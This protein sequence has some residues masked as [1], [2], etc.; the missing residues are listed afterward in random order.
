[1]SP[2]PLQNFEVIVV[3]GGHA[4]TE[5]A[6]AAAR[7][8]ARTL[9][10]THNIET[11]GQMSC[12]PAIG[13]IGKGH[14]VR[15][16]DALGGAM[17]HAADRAGIQW[18]T[19]NASKGPAVRATRCQADRVRYK[20]AIRSIVESQPDLFLFQ[21]AVDDL[22]I[23]GGRVRGIETQTGL[24]FHAPAIILTAGT[25]LAGK[26]H[27]GM[28]NHAG[29]RAGDAPAQRLA[30]RMR[31]LPIA[32][33]RLKTGTPPRIDGRTIDY[34]GLEEQ[35]GDNPTPLFSFMGSRTDHPPPV[36]CWITHTSERTHQII[37]GGLDRSPL[38]SGQIEGIG[39][40]YCPSIEDKVVRFADKSSHQIFIEPEG[41]DTY[42]IYPNG[43]STSLPFDV[44]LELVHSIRGFENAHITRPGYAI[45]Y[46]YFDP[47]GLKPSLETKAIEGLYFAGQINGTTGYEEAAAQGLIAG[48]NASRAVRGLAAWTPRRDE[49][50]IGVLID[51]LTTN[52]TIE[53]YRMFTSRAEYRLHLR[54]DN[55]DLRLSEIGHALGCVSDA[56][57]EQ[58]LRKREA[59]DTET[60]RLRALWVTP[61]NALG[62]AIDSAL[63][64]AVTRD[65]SVLDLLRRPELDYAKLTAVS[66]IGPAVSDALVAEQVEISIKYAGYLDRQRDEIERSRRHEDT[67]IPHGFD[68]D[69]V[70]GLSSEVLNKLKSSMPTTIGQA[71]RISGV[72]PAAISLLLVHLKRHARVA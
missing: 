13:G 44:Q 65:A 50:Y 21:Q 23:E 30:E 41:L 5:A 28:T 56:R 1:M 48:L 8:G 25:F 53:P 63:G 40:R 9:L 29:G 38:Y 15:E 37:R 3:G 71:Q 66:G 49:A 54:E 34:S 14:L 4:G 12:N 59:I 33:D 36:R 39:P 47:R 18:R 61:A 42:E 10:L 60:A 22:L 64:V 62:C 27:I 26:I 43:I 46:D 69:G 68:Y 16:I 51:D 55:A 52:G 20:A 57:H 58:V 6:L 11:I 45:E 31:E 17:A 7:S 32:V 19:L 67:G 70:R 24:R 35:P 2:I 72:T